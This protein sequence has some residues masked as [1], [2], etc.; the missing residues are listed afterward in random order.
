LLYAGTPVYTKIYRLHNSTAGQVA[1][2]QASYRPQEYKVRKALL[3]KKFWEE[4]IAYF[5]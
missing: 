1:E 2:I 5:P 4:L 3:N